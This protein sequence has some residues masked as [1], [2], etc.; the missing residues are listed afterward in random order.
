MEGLLT[1]R[2]GKFFLWCKSRRGE[3][4][5]PCSSCARIL[6]PPC[7]MLCRHWEAVLATI[8]VTTSDYCVYPK[9][10]I[11]QMPPLWKHSGGLGNTKAWYQ[12]TTN[13]FPLNCMLEELL[14]KN[15]LLHMN[16]FIIFPPCLLRRES[17]SNIIDCHF[18][19]SLMK[20][21]ALNTQIKLLALPSVM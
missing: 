1:W 12:I 15:H 17:S 7:K 4:L 9:H 8:R 10:G 16:H 6:E 5:S 3:K 11:D 18:S 19:E 13:N 21:A 2:V 14:F 20:A